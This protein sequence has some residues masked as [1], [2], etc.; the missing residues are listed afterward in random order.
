MA[1]I[2]K[3]VLWAVAAFYAYGALV[4]VLNIAGAS[5]FIWHESPLKWQALD[6]VYLAADVW[7]AGGLPRRARSAIVLFYAAAVS[8][9]VLYTAGRAWILDV[10]ADFAPAPDQVAYLDALVLFHLVTL[11]A[12]STAL[13]ALR[14]LDPRPDDTEDTP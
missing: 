1:T 10:P 6:I 4:H 7:V 3:A 9:I 2:A 13:L 14:R 12:V 11:T 8:Q 5:G